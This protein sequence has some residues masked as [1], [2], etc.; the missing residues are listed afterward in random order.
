MEKKTFHRGLVV[1]PV[2]H[3]FSAV[4][5]FCEEIK[6]LTTGYETFDKL[7]QVI[8]KNL[9]E[10]EFD[11][12]QDVIIPVGS[13]NANLLAGIVLEKIRRETGNPYLSLAVYKDKQYDVITLVEG[14]IDD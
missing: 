6:F 14:R 10:L 3:D 5:E 4:L 1:Q 2:G 12:K 11:P 8:R 7:E 13:V 9:E